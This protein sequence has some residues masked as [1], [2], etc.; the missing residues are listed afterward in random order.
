[1]IDILYIFNKYECGSGFRQ[2]IKQKQIKPVIPSKGLQK[3]SKEV[4]NEEMETTLNVSHESLRKAFSKKG[5]KTDQAFLAK[6]M[7]CWRGIDTP[8]QLML[9]EIAFVESDSFRSG[10]SLFK[11]ASAGMAQGGQLPLT[12][13]T[14][15]GTAWIPLVFAVIVCL[16]RVDDQSITAWRK[17]NLENLSPL[18]GKRKEIYFLLDEGQNLIFCPNPPV[19][20]FA[21]EER[22]LIHYVS[23]ICEKA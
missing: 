1:M 7:L 19:E 8:A 9:A 20:K 5:F 21:H 10:V 13:P 2:K 15:T 23:R 17:M 16:K 4:E 18:V 12:V 6:R 11:K 14:P 3:H 22:R